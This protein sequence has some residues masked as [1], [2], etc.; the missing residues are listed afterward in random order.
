MASGK[1]GEWGGGEQQPVMPAHMGTLK[2]HPTA[3][4]GTQTA[5]TP[6]SRG[7][8]EHRA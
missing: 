7:R 4:S 1:L 5:N 6:P 3:G 8:G 2:P